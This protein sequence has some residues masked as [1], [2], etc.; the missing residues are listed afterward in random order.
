VWKRFTIPSASARCGLCKRAE[1]AR[2]VETDVKRPTALW[3]AN[4]SDRRCKCSGPTALNCL[5]SPFQIVR[6]LFRT[7]RLDQSTAPTGKCPETR[8]LQG[9]RTRPWQCRRPGAPR[10]GRIAIKPYLTCSDCDSAQF[11]SHSSAHTRE[12]AH[13]SLWTAQAARWT[14]RANS[15][16]RGN[17]SCVT[18]RCYAESVSDVP[19]RSF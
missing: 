10:T 13:A 8:G 17:A 11:Q 7:R 1:A 16:P 4:C 9:V 3:P 2:S 6:N 18:S 5:G 12:C 15:A 19:A 14:G